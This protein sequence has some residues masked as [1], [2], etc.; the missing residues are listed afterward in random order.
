M[1]RNGRQKVRG[2]S[3]ANTI[4]KYNIGT[5]I[6]DAIQEVINLAKANQINYDLVYNNWFKFTV[7]PTTTLEYGLRLFFTKSMSQKN[8]AMGAVQEK[9]YV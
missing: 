6:G 2:I 1:S 8:L 9:Q 7:T 3:M 4:K 5:Y